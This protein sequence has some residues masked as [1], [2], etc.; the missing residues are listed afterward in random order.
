MNEFEQ[1]LTQ[2]HSRSISYQATKLGV[3]MEE[4]VEIMTHKGHYI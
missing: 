4:A 1:W 3:T 2:F